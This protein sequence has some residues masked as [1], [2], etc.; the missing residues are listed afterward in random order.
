MHACTYP[1]PPS[2]LAMTTW[3]AGG[4]GGVADDRS[5]ARTMMMMNRRACLLATT[6]SRRGCG[7]APTAASLWHVWFWTGSVIGRHWYWRVG[8]DWGLVEASSRACI[9]PLAH[10]HQEEASFDSAGRSR[11]GV[12]NPGQMS[13][14]QSCRQS[15]LN[16]M[17]VESIVVGAGRS[18]GW[19]GSAARV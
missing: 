12:A 17:D 2:R 15:Q 1:C 8:V 18:A 9:V 14:N 10:L 7:A 5:M 13:P 4:V 11:A 16:S 6:L 3:A 19:G